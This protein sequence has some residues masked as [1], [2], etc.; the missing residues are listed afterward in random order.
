[1]LSQD[2]NVLINNITSQTWHNRLGHLSFK[3]LESLKNKLSYT[4]YNKNMPCCICPLAKQHRLPFVSHNHP[5]TNVFDL[6]HCNVLGSY[7]VISHRGFRFFLTLVYDCSIFCWIYVIRNK[8]DDHII[9]LR[10]CAMVFN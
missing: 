7:F 3:R 1:M 6:I 8:F 2:S 4:S 5:S 10:F 9:I